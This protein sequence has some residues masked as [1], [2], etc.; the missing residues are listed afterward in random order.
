MNNKEA[1][2]EIFAWQEDDIDSDK[3]AQIES[4]HAQL[5]ILFNLHKNNKNVFQT[6]NDKF[7][8]NVMIN[9]LQRIVSSGNKNT[10]IPFELNSIR[11]LISNTINHLNIQ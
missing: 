8:A 9:S 1:I 5:A 3:W 7:Q 10:N 2:Q 11:E 4:L 6:Y